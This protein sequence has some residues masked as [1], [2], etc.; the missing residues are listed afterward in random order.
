MAAVDQERQ[1]F[2]AKVA[3]VWHGELGCVPTHQEGA[4]VG[5][6]TRGRG[7][8]GLGRPDRR[9]ERQTGQRAIF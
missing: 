4:Q 1:L 8:A 6:R 7:Q 5:Q 2:K 3:V 9:K